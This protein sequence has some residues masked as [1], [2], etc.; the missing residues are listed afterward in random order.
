MSLLGKVASIIDKFY[1]IAN[2][3]VFHIMVVLKSS[4]TDGVSYYSCSK[5]IKL[6]VTLCV[7]GSKAFAGQYILYFP[8]S[9]AISRYC[10]RTRAI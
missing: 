5:I 6:Y 1:D 4:N 7:G 3:G 2:I 8:A 10:P 9:R